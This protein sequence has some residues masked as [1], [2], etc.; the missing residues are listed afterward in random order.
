MYDSEN[1][2]A[3]VVK[4]PVIRIRPP[5][6]NKWFATAL[7]VTAVMTLLGAI[8][9]P[10]WLPRMIRWLVPPRYIATYL[11]IE[12]QRLIYYDINVDT[13]PTPSSVGDAA[14]LLEELGQTPQP[15]SPTPVIG[16]GPPLGSSPTPT[17]TAPD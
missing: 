3:Q 7:N 14:S 15:A 12:L 13:M 2:P 16:D 10:L 6:K 1:S 11:P 8:S 4:R 9:A 5:R 17:A